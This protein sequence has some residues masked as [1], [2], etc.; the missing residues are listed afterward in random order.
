MRSSMRNVLQGKIIEKQHREKQM[1]NATFVYSVY[2]LAVSLTRL[3]VVIV[4]VAREIH[5]RLGR[6]AEPTHSYRF[7]PTL[8]QLTLTF[9]Q[10]SDTDSSHHSKTH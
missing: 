1:S 10:L 8:P 6:R 7:E 3:G 2:L 4:P 5:E 9:S